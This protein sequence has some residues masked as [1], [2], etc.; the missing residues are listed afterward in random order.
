MLKADEIYNVS[1]DLTHC[2]LFRQEVNTVKLA[3]SVQLKHTVFV[4]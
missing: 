2:F 4:Q 1:S 3:D